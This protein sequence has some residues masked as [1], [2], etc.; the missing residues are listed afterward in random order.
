[1]N[2]P[3]LNPVE[4]ARYVL[5][6]KFEQLT[7]YTQKAVRMKIA[8][9]KWVEGLEYK[10]APDGHVLVDLQGYYRWVEKGPA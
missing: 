3:T 7:G 1:M 2:A 4:P 5:I 6:A 8:E 10:R 9:G